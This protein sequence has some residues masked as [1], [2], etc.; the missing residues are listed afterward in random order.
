MLVHFCPAPADAL[1]HG[2]RFAAIV[3]IIQEIVARQGLQERVSVQRGNYFHGDFADGYNLVLLSN[4]VQAEGVKT[5]QV[6]LGKVFKALRLSGQFASHDLMPN[7]DRVSPR[8][9][10]TFPLQM[11]LSFPERD[12]H[13]VEAI[14]GWAIRAGLA[15]L[16]VTC[17][18]SPAFSSQVTGG[19]PAYE[20]VSNQR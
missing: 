8:Q 9:P 18:P 15:D 10:A 19:K 2:V 3:P 4:S 17:L 7:P 12:T 14:C 13:P 16:A 5:C 11:L 20:R 6:L 1:R